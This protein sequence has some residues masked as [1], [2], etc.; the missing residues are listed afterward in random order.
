MTYIPTQS[1]FMNMEDSAKLLGAI[2]P[3]YPVLIPCYPVP[4]LDPIVQSSADRSN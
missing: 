2:F 1:G 4:T 3:N